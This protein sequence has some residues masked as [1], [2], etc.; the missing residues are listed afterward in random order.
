VIGVLGCEA[1]FD[2]NGRDPGGI[3]HRLV[4]DVAQVRSAEYPAATV[5]MEI[6]TGG[7]VRIDD[8]KV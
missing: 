8:A 3:D 6:H 7:F 4:T 5:E 1:V 2:R